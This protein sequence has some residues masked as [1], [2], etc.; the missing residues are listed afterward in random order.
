MKCGCCGRVNPED[1][2][3]CEGCGSQVR[4]PP[5]GEKPL[6]ATPI[7]RERRNPAVYLSISILGLFVV[8]LG[9]IA[10]THVRTDA[11]DPMETGDFYRPFG[12]FGEF[13]RGLFWTILIWALI[14]FGLLLVI[15]G[16]VI[17]V[18]ATFD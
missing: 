5:S 2:L 10:Y 1:T 8:F 15:A 3:F 12:G 7:R 9:V 16:L 13:V 11:S 14:I 18:A 4:F 17:T 6:L